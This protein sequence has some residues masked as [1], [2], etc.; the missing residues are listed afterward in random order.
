MKVN[1]LC[2]AIIDVEMARL[3]GA[4]REAHKKR[5]LCR[6]VSMRSSKACREIIG[7]FRIYGIV[8]IINV[9]M[10]L[11]GGIVTISVNAG[12]YISAWRRRENEDVASR[13]R[14]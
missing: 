4:A 9:A 11:T 14:P 7:H 12:M 5:V 13:A 10:K 3:G 1:M 2:A 6:Q 8:G